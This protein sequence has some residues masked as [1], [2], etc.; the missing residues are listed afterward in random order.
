MKTASFG[1]NFYIMRQRSR[2]ETKSYLLTANL[3]DRRVW[4]NVQLITHQKYIKRLGDS[5][6]R[7][8]RETV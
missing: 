2:L 5:E 6:K 4:P 1:I 8:S 3:S 7:Q